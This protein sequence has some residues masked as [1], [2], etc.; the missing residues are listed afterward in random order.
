LKSRLHARSP[1]VIVGAIEFREMKSVGHVNI[2]FRGGARNLSEEAGNKD[3][4][5]LKLNNQQASV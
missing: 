3:S 1:R 4:V 2:S 5:Q